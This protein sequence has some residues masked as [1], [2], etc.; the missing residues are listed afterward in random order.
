MNKPVRS[1][2]GGWMRMLAYPVSRPIQDIRASAQKVREAA[3]AVRAEREL[4]V[5]ANKAIEG[6]LK[7]I[8]PSRRFEEMAAALNWTEPQL[9][10]QAV[11][12]R[13]ARIGGLLAGAFA[14]GLVGWTMFLTSVW[15]VRLA[16]GSVAVV[17]VV[18]TLL[19]AVR[20]AWW[21]L[22]LEQRA[23]TSFRLFLCRE[24]M[25]RRVVRLRS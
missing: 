19:Q 1:A 13:R 3:Q 25:L 10:D 22:Q 14:F 12:A 23:L 8:A 4:N 24:D 7:D 15:W 16:L 20:H 11:A 9:R 18:G 17:M 21:E 2:V 6:M 5:E